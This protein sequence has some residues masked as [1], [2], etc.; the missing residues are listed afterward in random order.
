VA[1]EQRSGGRERSDGGGGMGMTTSLL[2]PDG[3]G[4]MGMT[5]SLLT[6][7]I[8]HREACRPVPGT[9]REAVVSA[10]ARWR[11]RD[12]DDSVPARAC[13]PPP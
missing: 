12:G 5:A 11:R 6:P 9:R 13:H 2:A 4:G 8:R 3:G 1:E 7:V 10:R